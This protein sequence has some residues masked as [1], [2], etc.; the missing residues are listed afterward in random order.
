MRREGASSRNR[1][2]ACEMGG[3]KVHDTETR[4]RENT[5]NQILFP[6]AVGA[7]FLVILVAGALLG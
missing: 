2:T 6:V 1:E 7:L 3:T 4:A 5:N